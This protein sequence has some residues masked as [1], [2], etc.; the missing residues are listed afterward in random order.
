MTGLET[1]TIWHDRM[2]SL[3]H[4]CVAVALAVLLWNIVLRLWRA[5]KE[6]RP[7]AVA[8]LVLI[9]AAV[10][11]T[12]KESIPPWVMA[13]AHAQQKVLKMVRDAER[14]AR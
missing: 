7:P 1:L 2:W 14:S 11:Y 12:V 6:L 3:V 5:G 9:F 4:L 8:A 13:E 10:V